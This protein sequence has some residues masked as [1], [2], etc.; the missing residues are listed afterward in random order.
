MTKTKVRT[1]TL[2]HAATGKPVAVGDVVGRYTVAKIWPYRSTIGP[3]VFE[4]GAFCKIKGQ[5]GLFPIRNDLLGVEW[6]EGE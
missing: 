3:G 5:N 2:Y 1:W 4:E 6:R